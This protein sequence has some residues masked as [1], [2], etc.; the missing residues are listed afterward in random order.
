MLGT[1]AVCSDVRQVH[2]GLLGGGQLNLGFL[3]RFFQALHGQRVAAQINAGVR[4]ELIRQEVDQ[5]Q[6]EIL[7]TQEGVTVGGQ[8]FKLVFTI[9]FG[10]FDDGDIESTAPQ[11]IYG[12][13][14]IT[15]FLVETISQS[16][17]GGLV[18]NTLH[19]QAGDATGIFSSLTLGIVEV[20]WHGDNGLGDRLTQVIFRGLL[21]FLQHLRRNLRRRHFLAF[22]FHPGIAIVSLGDLVGHHLDVLL[23][24]LVVKTTADQTLHRIQGIFRVGHR[25]TL[26]RL[27]DQG[28]LV[29]GVGDDGRRSARA[30]CVFNNL[31]LVTF[32]HGHTA[33]GRTQVDT[34]N[35]THSRS[36]SFTPAGTLS[37][38]QAVELLIR[39]API[40]RSRPAFQGSLLILSASLL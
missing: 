32:Q 6:V 24:H 8:H 39:L 29:V 14:A 31:G 23:N 20:S 33:V 34:D 5:C 9:H 37:A 4:L 16:S 15:T 2:F 10:N 35:L 22:H 38:P 17:R 19:V 18:D 12:D 13:G 26:G 7:T 25:L 36:I 27:T 1:G 28:F 3:G 40:W 11:V 21:H 30:F